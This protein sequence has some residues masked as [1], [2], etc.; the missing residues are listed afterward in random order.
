MPR[1]LL[2]SH[3]KTTPLSHSITAILTTPAP[4]LL[5]LWIWGCLF[6]VVNFG[7]KFTPIAA[8]EKPQPDLGDV[9]D[10]ACNDSVLD[11][12]VGTNDVAP[13]YCPHEFFSLCFIV[14]EIVH[15]ETS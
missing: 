2:P 15:D 11:F 7:N 9:L 14:R 6:L 1:P 13:K 5:L 12:L 3:I 10:S 4:G 8:L